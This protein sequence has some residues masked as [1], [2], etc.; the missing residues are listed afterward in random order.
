MAL[1]PGD[2][3]GAYEISGT[4]GA[5][6]M[7]EVYRAR[8]TSL[9]RAVALK[10]LPAAFAS[11]PDRL[12]RFTREAQ[13]LAALNHPGIA[14]IYGIH[15]GPVLVMELVEG[16]DLS[17]RL[18]RGPLPIDEALAA[19]AQIAEAMEA[20]HEQGIVHRDLK[21]ANIK[22][23]PDGSVKILDFGLA[24]AMDATGGAG[25]PASSLS[26]TL[27]SPALMTGIGMLLGTA[28]YM[29]PEQAKGRPADR[30]S[31]IWAFGC[32]LF[33]MLS[34]RPLFKGDTVTELLASV[35]KDRLEL[36]ALPPETPAATVRLLARCLERDPKQR[37]RDIGEARIALS[38]SA[39]DAQ[40]RAAPQTAAADS[41]VQRKSA[42]WPWTIAATTLAFAVIVTVL[43]APWRETTPLS[44]VRLNTELGV[45]ASL[46][47]EFGAAA[48]LSP[49][50]DRLAFVGQTAAGQPAQLYLRRLSSLQA[51]PVTGTV[52]AR[53]PF[54]SPDGQWVAFFADGKLKKVSVAGGAPIVLAD[55]PGPRGG[56][57]ADDDTI[58]F[59]PINAAGPNA[60]SLMR[61]SAS[62]GTVTRVIPLAEKEVTQRWPQVLPGGAVLFTS[63]V[64]TTLGYEGA[65]VVV[66]APPDGERKTLVRGGYYARYLPSGHVVYVHEGTLFAA[67]FDLS[68]LELT[69]AAVPIVEGI[70]TNAAFGGAQFAV[71][72]SGTLVYLPGDIRTRQFDVTPLLFVDRAGKSTTL[73]ATPAA[74]LDVSFAPDG[75]RLVVSIG[76]ETNINLWTL[77]TTRDTLSRLTFGEDT[78]VN[79]AWSPDGTRVAYVTG[80]IDADIYWQRA[81]GSG[82]AQRLTRRPGSKRGLAFHPNG[83]VLAFSEYDPRSNNIWDVMLLPLEG[84]EADG[85][86]P[87][88]AKP[89][90]ATPAVE[91]YPAFSPDGRWIAYASDETGRSEVYVRPYPGP[92]G[93]WQISTAGGSWP[94]WSRTRPELLFEEPAGSDLQL[95]VATYSVNGD[96]FSAERP[97]PWTS[98]RIGP[99]AWSL[100]PDGTRV[101]ATPPVQQLFVKRDKVVVFLNFFDDVRRRAAA[102]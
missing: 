67:P 64:S 47:I 41:G 89:F 24:K 85:W 71:S 4:L 55:A 53:D 28:A 57:W 44:P 66:Q 84:S 29:S 58:V 17:Q 61:V 63:H 13:T 70:T 65:S 37:L 9:N 91:R 92:G 69:A 1:S 93:K 72:A 49:D 74:W 73:R 54:F 60:G 82:A 52:G 48:V 32:V 31:D 43:W 8:D 77:D 50:G 30:R 45:D 34:G 68:R 11:D 16:E 95:M 99:R 75:N 15:E 97:R 96:A 81:D 3:L 42:W 10:I 56:T 2:R 27:T 5:G 23:R 80:L 102:K 20:A 79:S 100:H 83:K 21:P 22:M 33:E 59:Q 94:S 19:A 36:E 62:G 6:G 14:Q 38:R 90:L 26:P 7:G 12:A 88:E 25:V 86:K 39:S 46:D 98:A 78:E 18:A 87:G 40:E 35:M 51:T 101:A 76:D